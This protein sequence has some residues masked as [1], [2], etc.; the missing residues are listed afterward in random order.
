[1]VIASNIP[2]TAEGSRGTLGFR[3]QWKKSWVLPNQLIAVECYPTSSD[4][5]I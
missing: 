4:V 3:P 1:M 2:I 5:G